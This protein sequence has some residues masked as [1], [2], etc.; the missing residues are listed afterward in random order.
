MG[1]ENIVDDKGINGY[2]LAVTGMAIVFFVL[3]LVSLFIACLPRLLPIINSI[4]PPVQHHHHGPAAGS[5]RSPAAG[6]ENTD[7]ADDVI[8][9][10]GF[11]L[12]HHRG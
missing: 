2:A 4:L 7:D 11:A 6:R 5:A 12:H 8:A 1:F 9:A 10:I 3:V